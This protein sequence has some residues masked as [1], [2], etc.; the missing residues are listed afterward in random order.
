[1][2][3][4]TTKLKFPKTVAAV[5]ERETGLGMANAGNFL[6]GY[7]LIEEVGPP[8][9]DTTNDRSHRKLLAVARELRS[10]GF[11][12]YEL[13]TLRL[14]R[15]VAAAFP[16]DK[17]L[18]CYSWS[19]H[20]VAGDYETLCACVEYANQDPDVPKL[21]HNPDYPKLTV[22]YVQ[23]FIDQQAGKPDPDPGSAA[24]RARDIEV[25]LINDAREGL[26]LLA[27]HIPKLSLEDL[28]P[29]CDERDRFNK[30]FDEILNPQ[31]HQEAAE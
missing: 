11:K 9:D 1:V 15:R 18:S 17:R 26:N 3:D 28:K 4:T 27:P 16:H 20:W 23:W 30:R 29:L 10:L 14:F 19:V 6:I 22:G 8:R 2:L 7:A 5:R 25:A 12:G 13:V 31:I 21:K 24:E